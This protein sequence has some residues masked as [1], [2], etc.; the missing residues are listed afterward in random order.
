MSKVFLAIV[1]VVICLSVMIGIP[2]Y[3]YR[4]YKKLQH[5]K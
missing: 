3:L 2:V 4:K 5:K 1:F